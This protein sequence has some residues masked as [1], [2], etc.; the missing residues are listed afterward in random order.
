MSRSLK[1]NPEA[2]AYTCSPRHVQSVLEDLLEEIE[3]A[4]QL[5]DE[6]LSLN[7]NCLEI[8]A[9]KMNRLQELAKRLKHVGE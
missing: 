2:I 6:V 8:G 4:V 5:R 7:P 3:A 9:G 1:M